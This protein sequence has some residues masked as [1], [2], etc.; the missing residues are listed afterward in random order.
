MKRILTT[1][2]ALA[3]LAFPAL[4]TAE[5]W[6][7]DADHS[8]IGFT[9]RHMMVSNVKGT[10]GT[11]SGSAEVDEKDV[12]RSKISVT[13]DTASINTGVSK[14]DDHLRSADF[15]DT[16]KYPTMTYVSKKVEKS[17]NDRL[18]VYGDLTLRGVTKPVVLDV[19]GPTKAYKDPQGKLRR[20]ASATA[21]I[22]RKDF[23]L[24]W[25]KVIEAGGVLVGEEVNI[26]LEAEFVKK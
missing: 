4:A 25:N 7:I 14:R 11:F 22:N 19:E 16:A 20:G 26:S 6:S 1:V 17:G 24:T 18:K 21:T 23:G 3:L 9:V 10:F 13:I 12:T 8:S 5:T 2:A 15:F